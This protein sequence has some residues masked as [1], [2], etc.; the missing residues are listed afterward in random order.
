MAA[1]SSSVLGRTPWSVADH[2]VDQFSARRAGQR[3]GV[4]LVEPA[5]GDQ[6]SPA[7]QGG[8]LTKHLP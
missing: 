4:S 1:N 7:D 6:G 8:R 5:M 3:L 2:Q